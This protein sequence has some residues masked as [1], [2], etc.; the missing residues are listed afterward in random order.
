ML[1]AITS[2]S[3]RLNI[4]MLH[5][6]I[7]QPAHEGSDTGDGR[8]GNG[9]GGAS[10]EGRAGDFGLSNMSS[11]VRPTLYKMHGCSGTANLSLPFSKCDLTKC[12][13]LEFLALI[14]A[15]LGKVIILILSNRLF[16]HLR[17]PIS[18]FVTRMWANIFAM[19][20]PNLKFMA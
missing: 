19:H 16:E 6:Q 1:T 12:Y 15:V 14:C 8:R 11:L 18:S 10:G 20:Q 2:E 7:W 4:M 13:K 17:P 5:Q 9:V 3:I